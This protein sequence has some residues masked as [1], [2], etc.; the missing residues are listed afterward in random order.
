[1]VA[2]K[3]MFPPFSSSVFSVRMALSSL[4]EKL[5]PLASLWIASAKVSVMSV[6]VS[7][8]RAPAAGLK[9]GAAT[10]ASTVK[11]ASAADP[12]L[13]AAS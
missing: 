10:L 6:E 1:M 13:P 9:T 4:V 11:V 2:A 3:P 5:P 8:T 7:F 12:W